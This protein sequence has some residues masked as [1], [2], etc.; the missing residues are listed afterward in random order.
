[1]LDYSKT[2]YAAKL[3][4]VYRFLDENFLIIEEY[5]QK[6]HL[7][8]ADKLS[9]EEY[10]GTLL[11]AASNY[12]S[13]KTIK[14]K[15][16]RK[17]RKKRS[18]P[19]VNYKLLKEMKIMCDDMEKIPEIK[20]KQEFIIYLEKKKDEFTDRK[21]VYQ[22]K[23][24]IESLKDD[25]LYIKEMV[26][27]PIDFKKVT[28]DVTYYDA[29]IEDDKEFWQYFVPHEPRDKLDALDFFEINTWKNIL[30]LLPFGQVSDRINKI[31]RLYGIIKVDCDFTKEESRVINL[32]ERGKKTCYQKL[33]SSRYYE[34]I[35]SNTDI[36][37][38][39]KLN[40][41]DVFRLLDS[42]GAKLCNQFEQYFINNLY[43]VFLVRGEYKICNK[44]GAEKLIA[45]FAIDASCTDGHKS[46]CKQCIKDSLKRCSR[47]GKLLNKENMFGFDDRNIDGFKSICKNCDKSK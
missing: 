2:S 5:F 11:S 40:Q 46:I 31:I 12:L 9:N 3:K 23:K 38:K 36:T 35:I 33:D 22:I 45:N 1:L 15:Y 47:C 30:Q 39:L 24:W 26:L 13:Y 37:Y 7:K 28:P 6:V 16:H 17:T 43:Y 21:I 25:Q 14:K 4:E 44:C 10:G 32:M 20:Q 18:I 34:S 8:R 19:P 42:I 27:R 41:K 29:Y